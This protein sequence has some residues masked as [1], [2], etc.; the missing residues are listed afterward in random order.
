MLFRGK[1]WLL[2]LGF[3]IALV[4]AAIFAPSASSPLV[5]AEG[6]AAVDTPPLWLIVLTTLLAVVLLAGWA[7]FRPHQDGRYGRPGGRRPDDN[8]LAELRA[9]GLGRGLVCF[10]LARAS[11]LQR[12]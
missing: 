8:S 5:F 7:V 11:V 3:V 10:A 9:I 1:P 4:L 2:L 6:V 12:W